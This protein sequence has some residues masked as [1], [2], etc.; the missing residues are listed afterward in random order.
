M[1]R[2][3]LLFEKQVRQLTTR[4]QGKR[5][6][7]VFT[8]R[9]NEALFTLAEETALRISVDVNHPFFLLDKRVNV[10]QPKFEL[11][12]PLSGQTILS[13]HILNFDKYIRLETDRFFIDCI[14]FGQQP[15]ILLADKTEC[16]LDSFKEVRSPFLPQASQQY[17][18]REIRLQDLQ[19]LFRKEPQQKLAFFLKRHFKAFTKT[20]VSETLF[21]LNAAEGALLKDLPP[22]T[23]NALFAVFRR[24]QEEMQ[25][26]AAFLYL[27]EHKAG[28]IAP[29]RLTYFAAQSGV[30]EQEYADVN[31]AWLQFVQNTVHIEQFTRMFNQVKKALDKRKAY[32]QR[33]LKKIEE[34]EDLQKRKKT[35]EL[36]GNLLLTFKTKIKKGQLEAELQNIFSDKQEIVRIKL[37]PSKSVVENARRYFNKFKNISGQKQALQIKKNTR[38]DELKKINILIEKLAQTKTLNKLQNIRRQLVAMKLIQ[39]GRQKTGALSLQYAFNRLIL[40]NEWDVYIGKNGTNNDLLTFRFANKWDIWLHAQGVSG[41]HVIIRSQRRDYHPPQ[42]VI[43][44]AAQIAAA[45]SNAKHSATVPVIYTQA[46]FVH[47]VRK[48]LP[49]TVSVRNEKVIFVKP[50]EY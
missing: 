47:R 11:F 8:F 17:C 18:F 35:A 36:K 27:S 21:R 45:H 43:E 28:K 20:M 16:L 13:V 19:A 22:D 5:I 30:T 37:N 33:S 4:L 46:R 1:Q 42:K 7:S 41:S 25:A 26:A 3:Y 44:Q 14:F 15:N 34:N 39:D 38:L 31:S 48:A 9:R 50:M 2:N 29:F 6:V 40:E 32:L 23:L 12:K 49:G 24:I 10:H